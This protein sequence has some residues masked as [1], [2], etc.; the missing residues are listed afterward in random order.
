MKI[1]SFVLYLSFVSVPGVSSGRSAEHNS[2]TVYGYLFNRSIESAL[3]DNARPKHRVS[4]QD[5]VLYSYLDGKSAEGVRPHAVTDANGRFEFTGLA[6]GKR[7]AY[8]PGSVFQ[9]VEYY[10]EIVALA[11]DTVQKRSDVPVFESTGS[12][13]ALSAVMHHIIL[14]PAIG[15]LEVR[16]VTLFANRGRHTFVGNAPAGP[17][18]KNIVLRIDVPD[19]AT[20]V[21]FGGDLMSCC[22]VVNE[23][24]IFD[25]MELKPGMRQVVVN[26]LL[27]YQG[28]EASLIKRLTHPTDK[29]DVFLP[30]GA[31]TLQAPQFTSKPLFEIRG[32]NY[33]RFDAAD[34][35][36]G[37]VLTLVITGLASSPLDLRW[38]APVILGV[39]VIALFGIHWWRKSS[40]SGD[41]PSE[42]TLGNS[43]IAKKRQLLLD[44]ILRLDEAFEAGAIDE[45]TYVNSTEQLKQLVLGLDSKHNDSSLHELKRETEVDTDENR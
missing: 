35:K 19:E 24:H 42:Q 45:T 21:Q 34:L 36:A 17:P 5:V 27:P 38:L 41:E 37:S 13:S 14:K 33:Q 20:E 6:I 40:Q 29:V 44:E 11:P 16:E 2:G 12:D 43:L 3:P 23:N 30:E 8:Y 26:Y 9:G 39:S 1:L 18:G 10:G 22:A 31:G 28:K 25:T 15:A 4:G 7:F 32:E